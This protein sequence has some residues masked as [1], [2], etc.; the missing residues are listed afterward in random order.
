MLLR[1]V[2]EELSF[3]RTLVSLS[4]KYPR[5]ED[6]KQTIDWNVAKDPQRFDRVPGVPDGYVLRTTPIGDTPSFKVWFRYSEEE[7]GKVYLAAIAEVPQ[8]SAT[9]ES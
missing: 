8:E 1:E 5:I 7:P 6:V 4:S 3:T 9:G 2:V